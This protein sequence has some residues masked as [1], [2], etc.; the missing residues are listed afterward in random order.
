MESSEHRKRCA[1]VRKR[2][3]RAR[4][5]LLKVIQRYNVIS[6]EELEIHPRSS[7]IIERAFG[8]LSHKHSAWLLVF[9]A[10]AYGSCSYEEIADKMPDE[11]WEEDVEGDNDEELD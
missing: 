10:R 5:F 9:L 11:Y 7:E 2:F 1:L 4:K 3:E 6:F 8:E